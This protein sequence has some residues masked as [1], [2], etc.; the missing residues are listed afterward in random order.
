[1][2]VLM[3]PNGGNRDEDQPKNVLLN[4]VTQKMILLAWTC[5][6]PR[7]SEG[8]TANILPSLLSQ[9]DAFICGAPLM[10]LLLYR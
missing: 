10:I 2:Q 1:M 4:Q 3:G 9:Q 5:V 8:R 7:W 6:V